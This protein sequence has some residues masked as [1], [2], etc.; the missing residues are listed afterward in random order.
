MFQLDF[1]LSLQAK[2]SHGTSLETAG[3]TELRYDLFLGNV[4]L[5]NDSCNLDA[6]WGWIPL[7]DFASGIEKICIDLSS[8]SL[9]E[10]KFTFTENDETLNFELVE[11]NVVVSASYSSCEIV[12]P[13]A[14]FV[15]K[16]RSF[17]SRL[18][19]VVEADCPEIVRN[20]SYRSLFAAS[21]SS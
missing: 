4:I 5:R 15:M 2:N 16:V 18:R 21:I 17:I 10:A 1:E 6:A 19:G 8:Q 13:Q 3:A 14:E 7:L 9:N 12:V 20:A 11:G